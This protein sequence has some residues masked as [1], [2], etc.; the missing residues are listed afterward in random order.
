MSI[1][2]NGNNSKH[3]SAQGYPLD[4]TVT[5]DIEE[6]YNSLS[7]SPANDP[8]SFL[9]NETLNDYMSNL[10]GLQPA[11]E[12]YTRQRNMML[13][14]LETYFTGWELAEDMVNEAVMKIENGINPFVGR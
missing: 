4:V 10:A 12:T 8:A 2:K 5:F 7:I 3:V 14:N 11:A 9:F 6:L 13:Q 1:K